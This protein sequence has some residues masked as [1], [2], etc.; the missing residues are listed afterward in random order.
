[1]HKTLIINVRHVIKKKDEKEKKGKIT[2]EKC[3]NGVFVKSGNYKTEKRKYKLQSN[4][5]PP[6]FLQTLKKNT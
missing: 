2:N 1:M 3:K 5:T 4:N 6:Q